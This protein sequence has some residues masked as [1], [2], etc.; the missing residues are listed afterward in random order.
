METYLITQEEYKNL[1]K[2]LNNISER[3]NEL[4][5]PEQDKILD[6]QDIMQLLHISKRTLQNHR[7]K[8][9]LAY[10]K[11][12][13]KFYYKMSDVQ[14]LLDKNYVKAKMVA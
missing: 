7:D 11:V 5:T 8:R 1:I 12:G 10:S 13:N 4:E 9:M 14:K 6:S 3:I 2:Q